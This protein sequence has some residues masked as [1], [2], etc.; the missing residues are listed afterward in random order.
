MDIR[1]ILMQMIQL[2]LVIALGY[3]LFKIKLLDVDLNK[4]LTTLLLSVTT[5]AMIVSSVLSTTVTQGLND[6]LFVF[7]VGF[8]VYLIMPILG[9]IIVKI[10]RVPLPQQGLYIFMTVFSN[11]GFM[12]FPVMKAIFGNE[13]VFLLQY[14]I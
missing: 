7:L 3:F 13:A 8:A 5:P 4:K 14:L 6:I 12:G 9:Y 1:V 10:M 11:I 2:F